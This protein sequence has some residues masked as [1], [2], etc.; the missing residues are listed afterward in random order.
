MLA[1]T[2][3]VSRSLRHHR[4]VVGLRTF[5]ASSTDHTKLLKEAKIHCISQDGNT[6][7]IQQFVM[8]GDGMDFDM[9][10]KVPQLHLARIWMLDGKKIY[11]AKVVNRTL[12]DCPHVCSRLL[13]AALSEAGTTE[14]EAWATL[15]GLSDWVLQK[16]TI[17]SVVGG[18]LEEGQLQS[19]QSIAKNESTSS[20]TSTCRISDKEIWEELAKE[21]VNKGLSDESN[22]YR[23][24]GI[25]SRIEHQADTSEF[26][27]TC[28]GAMAV[29]RFS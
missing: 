17:E 23:E 10:K 8:A 6:N 26:A 16:D 15:H 21:F 27:N 22:L 2:A 19:V 9:V 13:D 29:F 4:P 20:D 24:R 18:K 5:F 7:G 28:G 1:C 14:A 11:G 3:G 12:G 25:L